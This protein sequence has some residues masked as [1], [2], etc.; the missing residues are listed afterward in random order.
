MDGIKCKKKLY[1]IDTIAEGIKQQNK[2]I[3]KQEEEVN[4]ILAEILGESFEIDKVPVTITDYS[5]EDNFVIVR[6]YRAFIGEDTMSFTFEEFADR[7][8]LEEGIE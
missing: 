1:Y 8:E 4:S 3:R 6:P 7:I 5:I 2:A